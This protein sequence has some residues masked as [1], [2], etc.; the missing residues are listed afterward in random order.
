MRAGGG[1]CARAQPGEGQPHPFP[2]LLRC[3]GRPPASAERRGDRGAG[4]HFCGVAAGQRVRLGAGSAPT[5]PRH[6][7]QPGAQS[8]LRGP[9]LHQLHPARA[10]CALDG[11][12]APGPGCLPPALLHDDP[13][14]Q[15]HHLH[16]GGSQLGARGVHRAR[17]AGRAGPGAA[18]AGRAARF[19]LGLLGDRGAA[20][21][22]LLPRP[23]AAVTRR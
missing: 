10:G 2:V 17:A 4:T 22:H 5:A 14:R 6:H 21:L 1:H 16:A 12:L 9:A 20:P 7:R 19:D 3:Q 11:G 23:P 15:R 13:E 18:G 8:F